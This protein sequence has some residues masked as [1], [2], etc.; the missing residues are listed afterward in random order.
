MYEPRDVKFALRFVIFSIDISLLL[1]RF[2]SAGFVVS[3][4]GRESEGVCG[5]STYA[6]AAR[7]IQSLH[8]QADRVA[9]NKD[10]E[11]QRNRL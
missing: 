6:A 8:L 7:E 3:N 2:L 1:T 10:G 4:S 11:S 5:K 9:A